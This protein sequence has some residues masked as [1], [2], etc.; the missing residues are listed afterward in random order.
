MVSY[1][2]WS[3]YLDPKFLK[4]SS[5]SESFKLPLRVV[6]PSAEPCS[7]TKWLQPPPFSKFTKMDGLLAIFISPTVLRWGQKSKFE[8][9]VDESSV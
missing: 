3:A 7:K 9:K 4:F 5:V 1:K 2:N 6:A 8:M